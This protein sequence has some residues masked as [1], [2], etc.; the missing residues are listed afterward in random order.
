MKV[1]IPIAALALAGCQTIEVPVPC[2]TQEQLAER[3]AAEPEKVG[4][5]LTGQADED[6]RVVAGSAVRLRSWGRGNL[7]LVR[8]C[9]E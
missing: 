3:E 9:A 2:L 1:L 8:A 5:Q 4:D 7:D 6:L